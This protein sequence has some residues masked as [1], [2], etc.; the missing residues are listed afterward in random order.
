M[1]KLPKDIKLLKRI[2]ERLDSLMKDQYTS[3]EIRSNE[4]YEYANRDKFLSSEF[5]NQIRYF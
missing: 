3:F 2:G 5:K 4:L 1:N